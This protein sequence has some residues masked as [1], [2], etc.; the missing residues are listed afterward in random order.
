[1]IKKSETFKLL[2]FLGTEKLTICTS[3]GYEVFCAPKLSL[4]LI[5]EP[6]YLTYNYSRDNKFHNFYHNMLK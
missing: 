6:P 5:F 4:G 1:M 3:S 2:Y